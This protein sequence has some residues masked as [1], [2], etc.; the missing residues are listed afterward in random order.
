[1]RYCYIEAV[2]KKLISG[3]LTLDCCSLQVACFEVVLFSLSERSVACEL[4][5]YIFVCRGQLYIVSNTH[6][7]HYVAVFELHFLFFRSLWM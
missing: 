2:A 1:M 7:K 6:H 3:K 5:V 4:N